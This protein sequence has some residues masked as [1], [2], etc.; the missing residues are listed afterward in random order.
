[1]GWKRQYELKTTLRDLAVYWKNT[2]RSS[3]DMLT[4]KTS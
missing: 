4:Q 2:I 3:G 1:V